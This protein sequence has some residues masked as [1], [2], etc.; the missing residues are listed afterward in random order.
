MKDVL[1]FR[2]FFLSHCYTPCLS[3]YVW[4]CY[5]VLLLCPFPSHS[6]PARYLRWR[7]L[8]SSRQGGGQQ[9]VQHLGFTFSFAGLFCS[10]FFLCAQ[11]SYTAVGDLTHTLKKKKKSS[12]TFLGFIAICIVSLD[13]YRDTY[14]IS[15]LLPIHTPTNTLVS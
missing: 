3:F 10:F 4:R 7:R 8:H 9:A 11:Q 5:A 13:T 15:R 2:S 12:G 6:A 1:I 14:R